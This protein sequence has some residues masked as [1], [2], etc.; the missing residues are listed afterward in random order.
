M[1]LRLANGKV[2]I[3]GEGD[4]PYL[5]VPFPTKT[6][7]IDLY[8]PRTSKEKIFMYWEIVNALRK[9]AFLSK[10]GEPF[11]LTK[12][13]VRQIEARFIRLFSEH[14][15]RVRSSSKTDS[16]GNSLPEDDNR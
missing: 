6:A 14:Y 13:R 2:P 15:W 9:G 5:L 12:E 7:F 11:G 8:E 1:N 3:R 4:S 10:A 16:H